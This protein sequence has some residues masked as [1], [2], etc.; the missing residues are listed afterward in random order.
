MKN[1][2][3]IIH[4]SYAQTFAVDE[5]YYAKTTD[6]FDLQI[7]KNHR[8]G[9]VMALDGIIQTTEKDE[10]IYH[11]MLTHVPL[12]AHGKAQRVLIIG[13]GDGGMLR[14][15]LKHPQ[16]QQV[17]QVEIDADVIATAKKYLPNHSQGAFDDP[18]LQLVIDDG[19]NFVANT[20]LRF[21]IIISDATDPIG[22]GEALF[23]EDFYSHCARCLNENGILV[24]QN[25]V[26]FFQ[27]QEA[28]DTAV[29]FNQYFKD[30]AFYSAAVPTYVGGIMLFGF[31]SQSKLARNTDISTLNS[32]F[33]QANIASKYYDPEIHI[34]SFAL[35]RQIKH[36]LAQAT[37]KT[38]PLDAD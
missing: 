14:E 6:N 30:W 27:L 11:E 25:G 37:H 24:T 1:F 3:E 7:F 20:E 33:T 32:R 28:L 36:Q 34:A 5:T 23:S 2:K 10:Y 4:D 16:V 15:V 35:P 29:H 18:R 38:Q 31:A 13:G 12:F 19:L 8:F 21:D 26:A 22:P 9:R 17:V